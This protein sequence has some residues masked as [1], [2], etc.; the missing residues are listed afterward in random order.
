MLAAYMK[1]NLFVPALCMSC[2]QSSL[3]CCQGNKINKL[4]GDYAILA[5]S[6]G[7][8]ARGG[9]HMQFVKVKPPETKYATRPGARV[10][11]REVALGRPGFEPGRILAWLSLWP[12][13][14]P[15]YLS[16]VWYFLMRCETVY[17]CSETVYMEATLRA[18]QAQLHHL[19]SHTNVVNTPARQ[20]TAVVKLQ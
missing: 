5:L 2:G 15:R 10:K 9:I 11:R 3:S 19:A 20:Y 1:S 14:G 8:A 18:M 13:Q 6:F 4:F 17:C 16:Q 12:S 7:L